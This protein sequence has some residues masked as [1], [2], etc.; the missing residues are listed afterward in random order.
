[1]PELIFKGKEFVFNH[2]LTVPYRPLLPDAEKSAGEVDLNGNLIVH[3]DNLHALK[4]LLPQYA[5]KVDC[6]F[7]DPPYNTG[8]ENWCYNDNLNN[9]IMQEWID[10]NPVNIEDGLR[11]DK[12]CAMMWP[13]LKLLHE[14]LSD[15]GIICITLD[16]NEIHNAREICDDIFGDS[17]FIA[18]ISW[19][20]RYTRSN[21]ANLF[22]SIKDYILIY[23]KSDA[24]TILKEPRNAKSDSEYSNSDNDPRGPWTTSSYVNPATRAQRPNLCYKITNPTTGEE[25]EHPTHAWKYKL[26]EH[27]RHVA[28]SLLWWGSDGQALYPRLKLFLND[29]DPMVPVDV[30]SYSEVGSSDDGG[31]EL[32]RIFGELVFDNPKPTGLINKVLSLL[33]NN[34]IILDAFAGSGST[35]HA[36]LTAN[37]SD[38]GSR[39]FILIESEH[40]TNTVTA[41]RLRRV[42]NGYPYQGTQKEGI[43]KEKLT[44]ARFQKAQETI[45]KVAGLEALHEGKYDRIKKEIKDG[46]LVVYGEK[47]IEATMPGLGGS[48]TYCTLGEP[49]N[50]DALLNGENLP[51]YIALGGWVFHTATG[52]ALPEGQ[53][54]PTDFYLGESSA[55]HVWLIYKPDLDFLKSGDSA[56]TL[57]RAEK[58]SKSKS[59]DKKHLVFAPAKFVPNK[60]LLD[61]RVEFAQ[62]PYALYRRE[63]A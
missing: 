19:V 49:F 10:S 60:A 61:K 36:V 46:E 24:L 2:H 31:E 51:D 15:T 34:S 62:L 53:A 20:K 16:D 1:M 6:I 56:L 59:D 22:Y 25:I 7:I 13:R 29:A 50:M 43:F 32:K 33:P 12:W 35:G 45:Q 30:W 4:A 17:N 26:E 55:Y 14:M 9:P 21:N 5:G 54:L 63:Q 44:W 27:Q 3:G 37:A 28:E 11:H 57:S 48:F 42:I 47:T 23:R 39:R 18:N 8:N 52:E 41:E 58:I 40:Y 38:K